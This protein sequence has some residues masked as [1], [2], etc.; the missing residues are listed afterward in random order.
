MGLHEIWLL[1]LNKWTDGDFTLCKKQNHLSNAYAAADDG[2]NNDN[3]DNEDNDGNDNNDD[4][5][6]AAADDV[7]AVTVMILM[8]TRTI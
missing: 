8:P 4:N 5:D 3:G 7:V 1:P 2:D 6:N